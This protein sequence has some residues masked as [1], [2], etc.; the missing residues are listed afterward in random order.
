[1]SILKV[2]LAQITPIWLNKKKTLAKVGE[3][4]TMAATENCQLV[5]FGEGLLP[6]YPFWVSF[7]NGSSFNDSRQKEIFAHYLD[8]GVCIETGDLDNICALA[9]KHRIAIYLGIIERPKDRS[10]LSL[11]CSL[12]YINQEGHIRSVHRKLQPTFEE[13]LVWASGDG[14]GLRTHDLGSFRLGGLNCWENWMPLSRAALYGM[15]ESLHIAVWPGMLRNTEDIT[16]FLAK[17]GRSFSISV[18]G[19]L[20]KDEI[21]RDIPHY[22]YIISSAPDI[23]AEGGSCIAAPD[24]SWLLEPQLGEGLFCAELDYQFVLQERQNFDPAGHY[25]RPDITKVLV[26]RERQSIVKLTD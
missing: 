11:Y 12:V 20:R 8:Q 3:Y 24:G 6:G 13:R 14:H 26:N 5:V 2:G 4:I 18:S 15:G 25:S 22:D 16:P 9:K 17:E 23:L 7:T 21:P 19:L 1:M 10:G